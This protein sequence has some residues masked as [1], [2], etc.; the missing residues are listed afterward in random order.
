V[1]LA[2]RLR[3]FYEEKA[4]MN[5]SYGGKGLPM[6][7]NLIDTRKELSK[8]AGVSDTQNP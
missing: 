2:E 3:P 1:Q 7:T 4:K 5:M 6:L 8:K